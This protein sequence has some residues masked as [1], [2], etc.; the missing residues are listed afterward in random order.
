MYGVV[1]M[2]IDLYLFDKKQISIYDEE[3]FAFYIGAFIT[4]GPWLV[5]FFGLTKIRR[6]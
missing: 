3:W 5:F 1:P 6:S 2:Q 4:P